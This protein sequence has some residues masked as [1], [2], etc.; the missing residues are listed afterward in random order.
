M[1]VYRFRVTFEDN[2]DV[3]REIEIKSSQNFEDFHN[4]ILES[5]GFDNKHE[6]S[7]FISNDH[8][9]KGDEIALKAPAKKEEDDDSRKKTAVR[10]IR[11]MNKCKLLSLIDDPHQ[12]FVYEYDYNVGWLFLVELTKILPDNDKIN[13]PKCSKSVGEAPK[14]YKTNNVVPVVI[15]DEDGEEI[16][17]AKLIDDVAYTAIAADE[18]TDL[19]EG[20]EGEEVKE[21]ADDEIIAI[22]T[23][24]EESDDEIG[25]ESFNESFDED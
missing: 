13:Y 17:D 24:E 12:K 16:I 18:D 22:D 14:Q 8:W 10:V 21:D 25:K 2:E 4:A 7:F 23:E 1:A 5:F 15:D 11:Q 9:H 19:L 20:V 6:G 3:F